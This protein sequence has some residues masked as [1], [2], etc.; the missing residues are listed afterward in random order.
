MGIVWSVGLL[1][2][3]GVELDL[4]SVFAVLMSIGVGVDY[5]VHLLHR[6]QTDANQDVIATLAE[7]GPAILIAASTTI[8]GFG[9]LVTSSYGPL[10]AL[11]LV[12]SLAITGCVVTSLIVLPAWLARR[13]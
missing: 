3:A 10:R 7:T 1:A 12:S 9:S 11:G 13:S 6:A 5:A 8:I 4:F 2:L